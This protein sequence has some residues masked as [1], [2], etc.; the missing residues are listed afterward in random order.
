VRLTLTSSV[1][2]ISL[3]R[4][5]NGT[6]AN[7]GSASF[8]WAKGDQV[9]IRFQTIGTALKVRAWLAGDPEP[10][11]WLIE[12]TDPIH[13]SGWSGDYTEGGGG[14]VY[15]IGASTEVGTPAPLAAATTA[16][17]APTGLTA[18]ANGHNQI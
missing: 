8:T 7:L 18:T 4:Y 1:P 14:T 3:D 5:I 16:P 2:A 9:Y 13:G 12:N 10:G 15:A 6:R 17:D 11:T